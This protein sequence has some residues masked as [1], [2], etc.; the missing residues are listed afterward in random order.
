MIDC[1]SCYN[2]LLVPSSALTNS[3][4][5]GG[6]TCCPAVAP[7]GRRLFQTRPAYDY[8]VANVSTNSSDSYCGP[9]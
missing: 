9:R 4:C 1:C 7:Q 8:C 5:A 2:S 3:T 6:S